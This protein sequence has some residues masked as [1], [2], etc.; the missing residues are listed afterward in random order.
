M[1]NA[2]WGV[3]VTQAPFP[4]LPAGG[5]HEAGGIEVGMG[6]LCMRQFYMDSCA[7]GAYA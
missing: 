3:W 2:A 5:A 1:G 7:W 6:R 4:Q